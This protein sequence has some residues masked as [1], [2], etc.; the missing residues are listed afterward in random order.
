M[1]S[2]ILVLRLSL[3]YSLSYAMY[4]CSYLIAV[5]III[6]FKYEEAF[7]VGEGTVSVASIVTI[8][9]VYIHHSHIPLSNIPCALSSCGQSDIFLNLLPLPLLVSFFRL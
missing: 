4:Y 6:M 8:I 7:F 1:L 9:I 5:I 3:P 2:Y